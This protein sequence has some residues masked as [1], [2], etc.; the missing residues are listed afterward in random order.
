MKTLKIILGVLLLMGL[1]GSIIGFFK[2]VNNYE[3]S[4][5]FG[6]LIAIA[7]I[8]WAVYALLKPSKTK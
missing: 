3:A 5:L 6:H 2:E 7:L 1:L 8:S 4:D